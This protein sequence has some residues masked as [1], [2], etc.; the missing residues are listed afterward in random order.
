VLCLT[1]YLKST[2]KRKEINMHILQ[3]VFTA[4]H[5]QAL[6]FKSGKTGL[7]CIPTTQLRDHFIIA[8][9]GIDAEGRTL[10]AVDETRGVWD[11]VSKGVAENANVRETVMR[12]EGEEMEV[13]QWIG[14]V[15]LVPGS[16]KNVKGKDVLDI[17]NSKISA[18][19]SGKHD[20][21]LYDMSNSS[22]EV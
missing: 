7:P 1:H 19:P 9:G 14:S 8:V 2:V 12:V 11:R 17:Q 6:D 10:W 22:M 16:A 15:G 4:L 18:H 3:D 13:W 5:R 21:T 20:D